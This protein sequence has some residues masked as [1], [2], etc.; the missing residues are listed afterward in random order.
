[1]DIAFYHSSDLDGHCS[2]AIVKHKFPDCEMIGINYG[3]KIDTTD[4][5][6][7]DVIMVDFGL[8]LKQMFDLEHY[9]KSLT[10]IDHH[11]TT[12]ESLAV[13]TLLWKDTTTI[14]CEIGTAGCELTW[15]HLY[16]DIEM[17]PTVYMLG[18]YDVWDHTTAPNTLPFQYGM[19]ARHTE[20]N[21]TIWFSL[22]S[23]RHEDWYDSMEEI[24]KAGKIII[25]YDK[26]SNTK[27][28]KAQAFETKICRREHDPFYRD[29][30]PAPSTP[31]LS[32]NAIAINRL[33]INSNAFESVYNPDIHDLMLAF[34]RNADGNWTCSLYTTHDDVDVSEIAKSYGGGGHQKAAG[35]Q[36]DWPPPFKV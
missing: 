11:K 1:M 19:R 7:K 32:Y 13:N 9:A 20:P 31:Y 23:S 15:E 26:Q 4:C 17:P 16:P 27:A 24:I 8:P 5:I 12:K 3:Q 33:L 22:L 18:R 29:D 34:G 6:D 2:G 10:W 30:M 35:F 14:I 28:M 36:F 25:A 21:S